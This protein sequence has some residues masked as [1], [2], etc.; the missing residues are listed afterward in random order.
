VK[1]GFEVKVSL[2]MIQIGRIVNAFNV[3]FRIYT[4]LF[5]VPNKANLNNNRGEQVASIFPGLPQES[6]GGPGGCAGTA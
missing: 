4:P 3:T 2:I 1:L 6:H 5:I